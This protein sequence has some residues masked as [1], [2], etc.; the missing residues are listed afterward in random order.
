MY[1][2]K[3]LKNCNFELK[4]VKLKGLVGSY[5]KIASLEKIQQL[6]DDASVEIVEKP[7]KKATP[8]TNTKNK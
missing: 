3:F 4:G 1:K 2:V 5:M 6:V 8:K 7:K